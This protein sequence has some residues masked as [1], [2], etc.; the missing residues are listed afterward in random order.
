MSIPVLPRPSLPALPRLPGGVPRVET[1]TFG[2][3]KAGQPLRDEYGLP[4]SYQNYGPEQRRLIR[5]AFQGA[6]YPVTEKPPLRATIPEWI[7]FGL[8]LDWTF[9][10]RQGVMGGYRHFTFQSYELGG[11]QPGGAV[12]DFMVYYNGTAVAVRVHS[13]YHEAVSP[14]GDGGQKSVTDTR[15]RLQL[16]A[17]RFISRVVDVNSSPERALE[18]GSRQQVQA[19]IH[20]VLGWMAE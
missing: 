14:F 16:M 1:F 20:K 18:V 8:L 5:R 12:V 4:P 10:W 2:E 3:L 13:V 19:E 9:E 11:R 17:S 15:S 7:F 6:G